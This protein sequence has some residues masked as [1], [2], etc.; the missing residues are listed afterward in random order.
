MRL[1]H[2]LAEHRKFFEREGTC[3]LAIG[4]PAH[5]ACRIVVDHSVAAS[6]L[7]DRCEHAQGACGHTA[8]AGG[9][10]GASVCGPRSRRFAGGDVSLKIPD[11]LLGQPAYRA[12]S[13]QRLDML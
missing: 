13:D 10:A 11:I 2:R 8:P 9:D 12:T 3:L 1:A 6:M 7:E 4:E 5:A